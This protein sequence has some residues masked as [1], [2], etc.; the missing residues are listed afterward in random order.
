MLFRFAKTGASVSLNRPMSAQTDHGSA[1][2][3]VIV[4]MP[5]RKSLLR[6]GST[7]PCAVRGGRGTTRR[8]CARCSEVNPSSRACSIASHVRMKAAFSAPSTIWF[9]ARREEDLVLTEEIANLEDDIHLAEELTQWIPLETP[10]EDEVAAG[11]RYSV[12]HG[13]RIVKQFSDSAVSGLGAPDGCA[14]ATGML[15]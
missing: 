2:P 4:T 5:S 8:S 14:D 3:S 7:A 13:L 9:S 15:Q 12:A 11:E 1:P 6:E 10:E